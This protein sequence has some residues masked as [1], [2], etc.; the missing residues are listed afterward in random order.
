MFESS[1]RE[2]G[3]ISGAGRAFL[4]QAKRR[5][6]G[7]HTIPSIPHPQTGLDQPSPNP[8]KNTCILIIDARNTT[9]TH[10]TQPQPM[11]SNNEPF[12]S[13]RT[14]PSTIIQSHIPMI[15][16]SRFPSYTQPSKAHTCQ[17]PLPELALR[18]SAD[19][20]S[21]SPPSTTYTPLRA[22]STRA[23]RGSHR[24]D[25]LPSASRYGPV[26]ACTLA[27]FRSHIFDAQVFALFC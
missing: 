3:P 5:R 17:T 8:F 1:C 14:G 15:F 7:F 25:P 12:K 23:P 22:R 4:S 27:P 21:V 9:L 20:N 26:A 24:R 10:P 18:L 19:S 2:F 11:T 6:T 13:S 16:V